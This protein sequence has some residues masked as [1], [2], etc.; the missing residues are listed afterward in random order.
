LFMRGSGF[1]LNSLFFKCMSVD[2][3]LRLLSG[4]PRAYLQDEQPQ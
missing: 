4:G 3:G 2:T 1:H